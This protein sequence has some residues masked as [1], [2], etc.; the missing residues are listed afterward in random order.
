MLIHALSCR[1]GAWFGKEV[2]DDDGARAA[3]KIK[4]K[5]EKS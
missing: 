5:Q 2:N 1:N 4:E 3:K